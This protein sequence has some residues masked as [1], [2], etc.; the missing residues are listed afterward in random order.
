MSCKTK[1]L[2]D[3]SH[4]LAG[5][6][7]EQKEYPWQILPII[8]DI[9]MDIIPLLSKE[10]Y[11]EVS[12]DI[13]IHKSAKVSPS[14]FIGGPCIIGPNTEIRHGAFIRN[15]A[16]IGANC[17]IGNSCEIKNAIVFDDVQVPHFNYVGDSILG[18]HSHMG[19]GAVASNVKADKSPIKVRDGLIV[20][21]TNLDSFGTILGD[22]V[23]VGCNSV[24]NPGTIVG[25]GST[26]YPLSSA[27]GVIAP[28]C[29]YKTKD[30]IVEKQDMD[31][32]ER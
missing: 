21:E 18:Y 16:L 2:L 6:Y 5:K 26:I 4:S 7:L 23:E 11:R 25:R 17:V 31:S 8:G 22:Y 3:L 19:A 9:I 15:R 13:Y 27:R 28:N 12:K 29:I 1:E 20:I 14:A 32:K 30:N 24:L 10:E